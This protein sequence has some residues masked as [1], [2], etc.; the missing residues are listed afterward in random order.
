M[1]PGQMLPFPDFWVPHPIP[2]PPTFALD[3]V[4]EEKYAVGQGDKPL[5]LLSFNNALTNG[6]GANRLTWVSSPGKRR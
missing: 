6:S 4:A 1:K 5:K 2:T 3:N